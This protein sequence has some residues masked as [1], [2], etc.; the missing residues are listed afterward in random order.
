MKSHVIIFFTIFLVASLGFVLKDSEEMSFT[1]YELNLPKGV[2]LPIIPADNEL[3][4]ERVQLG[5]MLF[6]DNILSSDN[7]IS[8]SSCHAPEKSFSDGRSMSLGVHDSIG[9]RNAMPLVNL[10][11]SNS[12]FWDGGAKSLELQILKPLTSHS[13]MNMDLDH[14]IQRLNKN[15][16]YRKLFMKAYGSKP[17]AATLFKALASFERTL[18][19][20]NSKYDRRSR[21]SG[22]GFE[23]TETRGFYL[24]VGGQTHCTSCHSGILFTNNSFQNNGLSET[25][26]DEGR[27]K[28]TGNEN[29]KGK[30]KVPTLRNIA[31][32]APYMHDGSIKTLEEVVEH[33]NSGGKLHPNKSPHV[34][35]N[36]SPPLTEEQKT[37]LV[38]FLKTLTD[39]EFLNNPAFR[40]DKK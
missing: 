37:D 34:H 40:P 30:F 24:F 39:E 7:S 18:I 35:N 9:E 20:F 32:T 17:D 15:K 21:N 2:P 25:Y 22:S 3:S 1:K 27:F 5:K 6:Y 33:Y 8:C 29:D 23:S 31:V 10:A 26:A 38:N 13:E 16:I 11:W 14:T 4:M 28:I 36:D 19:S 12:F